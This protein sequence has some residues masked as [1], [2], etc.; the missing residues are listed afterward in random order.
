MTADSTPPI[1]VAVAGASGLLGSALVRK[2]AADGHGVLRLVR[3]APRGADEI[4]WDPAAGTVDAAALEGVDAVVNLAG[5]SVAERWTE[6]RKAR[7]R[8]SRA[9]ATR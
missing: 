3:R 7:I 1:R 6:A 2:L 9:G 8:A 5:E 4:R